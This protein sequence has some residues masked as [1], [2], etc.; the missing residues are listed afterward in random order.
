MPQAVLSVEV[1]EDTASVPALMVATDVADVDGDALTVALSDRSSNEGALFSTAPTVSLDTDTSVI[2]LQGGA[3]NANANGV[4]TAVV[5]LSDG[6]ATV[7]VGTATV[8]V[9]AVN[10]APTYAAGVLSVEVAEDTAGRCTA[11]TVD[12][13]NGCSPT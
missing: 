12:G 6:D 3:L 4:W 10:D 9:T 13:G 2:V 8:N 5:E 1:A 11:D 7:P